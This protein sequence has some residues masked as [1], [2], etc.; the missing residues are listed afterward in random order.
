MLRVGLA[1]VKVQLYLHP[2]LSKVL[3]KLSDKKLQFGA[4]IVQW[5]RVI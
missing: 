5:I 1:E 2:L 3:L 4:I